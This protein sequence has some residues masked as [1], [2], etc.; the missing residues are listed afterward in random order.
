MELSEF[1]RGA[2]TCVAHVSVTRRMLANI[3]AFRCTHLGGGNKW[4]NWVLF[5]LHRLV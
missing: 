1:L 5:H 2:Y 3:F 4:T